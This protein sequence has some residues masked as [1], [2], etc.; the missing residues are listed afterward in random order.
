MCVGMWGSWGCGGAETPGE[1][2]GRAG[3]GG[4]ESP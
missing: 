2:L 4:A 1:S 3:S